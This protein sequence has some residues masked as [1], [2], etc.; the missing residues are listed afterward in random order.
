MQP[1]ATP[2]GARDGGT[3]AM[4][5]GFN[6]ASN[7][8]L[9]GAS[10]SWLGFPDASTDF[11]E[12][13]DVD[14]MGAG[15]MVGF[16]KSHMRGI[17][18]PFAA[19]VE[20]LH[21]TVISL[22]ENVNDLRARAES[23]KIGLSEQGNVV[24]GLRTDVDHAI[25]LE[26]S[27]H[28]LLE[29]TR[30][31]KAELEVAM[32]AAQEVARQTIEKLE[33]HRGH[34]QRSQEEFRRNIDELKAKIGK[35]QD[36]E[37]KYQI[38]SVRCNMSIERL[39]T[40]LSSLEQ[41]H[42]KTVA[43][44]NS[45]HTALG[46]F[47]AETQT[48]L[49]DFEVKRSKVEKINDIK[50]EELHKKIVEALNYS[51]EIP[52]LLSQ[53]RDS[54]TQLQTM[55]EKVDQ[56]SQ[57]IE[58]VRT[59][60][61]QI[62]GI[63][64]EHAA[65]AGQLG[66][67]LSSFMQTTENKHLQSTKDLRKFIERTAVDVNKSSR[68]LKDINNMI[69]GEGKKDDHGQV[70][71]GKNAFQQMQHDIKHSLKQALRIE[72]VMG[73]PSMSADED[74]DGGG[75]F[76]HGT[77]LTDQQIDEFRMIFQ[78]FDADGS[79]N[80]CT[81][82]IVDVLKH[83]HFEVPS[84]VLDHIIKDIDEDGSGEIC[85]DEFCSLMAKILGPDGSVNVDAY[86]KALSGEATQ[87]QMVEMVPSLKEEITKHQ[88]VIHEEQQKLEDASSRLQF[89]EAEH[90][91]LV[92]EVL[93]MRKGMQL[94]SQNWKGL[95]DGFKDTKKIVQQ[96]GEGEMMPSAT[97]LRRVLPSLTPRPGSANGEYRP[98]TSAGPY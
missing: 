72:S 83:L 28:R 38:E 73:L 16:V 12:S 5:M 14:D 87:K 91:S 84:D 56:A 68:L 35:C 41:A 94:N 33:N 63:L 24:A 49:A 42:G 92:S 67:T 44:L 66:D 96:E 69:Q 20:E 93:K 32:E 43:G 71:E 15:G 88:V 55:G 9:A 98:A 34:Q 60:S 13:K 81:C 45:T 78:R 53:L 25:A 77:M 54:T 57:T 4:G 46:S 23:N 27:T 95:A 10:G 18:Q 31:E 2:K 7:S 62:D 3:G 37:T 11:A 21:K 65:R 82:E 30:T 64:S 1:P 76:R 90:S 75:F 50:M 17:L 48:Q 51:G 36:A 86:V 74:E 6:T 40:S 29:T 85:F 19:N 59:R 8:S 47:A 26:T 52:W 70:T 89:L 97:R 58:V 61:N 79:G 80:I 22:A 39:A